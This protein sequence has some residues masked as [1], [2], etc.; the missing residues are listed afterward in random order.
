MLF[1]TNL[2]QES[3]TLCP[4]EEYILVDGQLIKVEEGDKDDGNTQ[5]RNV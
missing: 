3:Y 4:E 2:E 5:E 1:N